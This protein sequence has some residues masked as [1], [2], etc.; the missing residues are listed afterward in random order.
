MTQLTP[1]TE[2]EAAGLVR[3]GR[4]LSVEGGATRAGLGR[5]IQTDATLSTRGLS[6]ITIYEPAELVISA[7]AGTPLGEI[8]AALAS[9]GQILPFEPMDHRAL[10]GT[11]GEPTIG[12]VAACN[13]S[14]PRRVRAG[15]ARDSLIGLRLVNGRGEVVKTGGRVMKNV[16]GLDLV[17]LNCGAHGT[18][19]VLTEVTFKLLPKPQR[20][21]TLVIEGLDDASAIAALSV[22]L[23]SPFE[24]SGAAHLP[25]MEE[26]GEPARTLVR[27]EHFENSVVYRLGELQKALGRFGSLRTL[28][29]DEALALWRDVRDVAPLAGGSFGALWR[30]HAAPSRAAGLVAELRT[31]GLARSWF[32]D[33]G[34]GLV[35]L[36]S[37]VDALDGGGVHRAAAAAQGHAMLV[38]APVEA[39]A[40][41]D[42]FQPLQRGLMDITARVKASFDPNALINPGRMYAGV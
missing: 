35:W 26:T 6:G 29:E 3:E 38:R 12:G 23:G 8:E 5:P 39:R 4:T 33:W 9:K 31:Q 7:R 2:L 27:I 32:Y 14:G 11:H 28:P 36:A 16:T 17:K 40:R 30:I 15:A 19:G 10:Y 13:V 34:G 25:A 24:V 21:G 22:A 1:T 42:V 20:T 37:D 41:I 18:L